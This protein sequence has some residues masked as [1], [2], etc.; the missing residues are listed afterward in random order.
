MGADPQKTALPCSFWPAGS[1][2]DETLGKHGSSRPSILS[3]L[4]GAALLPTDED[5]YGPTAA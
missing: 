4:I 3:S 5:Q 2:V 1:S